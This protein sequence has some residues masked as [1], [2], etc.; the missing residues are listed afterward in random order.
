MQRNLQVFKEK[1]SYISS[2]IYLYVAL[3]SI[4]KWNIRKLYW[5]A[6]VL[7]KEFTFLEYVS[8]LVLSFVFY[9]PAYYKNSLLFDFNYLLFT[10]SSFPSW[11][12]AVTPY[13]EYSL[14]NMTTTLKLHL[15]SSYFLTLKQ[16]AIE[17]L[18]FWRS[19]IHKSNFIM[20][21]QSINC[22]HKT[23]TSLCT[24]ATNTEI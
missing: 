16:L 9:F 4:T 8:F 14:I 21:K 3:V 19:F 23:W 1:Q 22:Y 5:L 17:H 11:Q 13:A 7:Q 6:N 10:L 2:K 20:Q 18:L 15:N 24:E 12:D